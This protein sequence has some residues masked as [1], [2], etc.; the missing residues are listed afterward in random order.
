MVL[1]E[2]VDIRHRAS[3]RCLCRSYARCSYDQTGEL[4]RAL[5]KEAIPK[6]GLALDTERAFI[7]PICTT[8]PLP[9]RSTAARKSACQSS[10]YWVRNARSQ[11]RSGRSHISVDLIA[12]G[13]QLV[14]VR[15]QEIVARQRQ[16]YAIEPNE[17]AARAGRLRTP[18]RPRTTALM[19]GHDRTPASF[20]WPCTLPP[21]G[22]SAIG[23]QTLCG[24]HGQILHC[25]LH[26][27]PL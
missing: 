17:Y 25:A 12:S 10:N 22:E 23:V 19:F 7:A 24:G 14:V 13:G 1:L 8:R 16:T 21:S 27:T 20:N 2:D 15:Q 3:R 5:S 26:T 11:E 9:E 4:F 18:V 6:R